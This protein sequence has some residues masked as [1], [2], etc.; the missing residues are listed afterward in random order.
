MN[1]K[2]YMPKIIFQKKN[3][4]YEILNH[5]YFGRKFVFLRASLGRF[6]SV[7]FYFMSLT[8]LATDI[9]TQS[10]A[11]LPHHK[12][13]SYDPGKRANIEFENDLQNYRK[14]EYVKT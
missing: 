13:A 11:P 5:L 12:K 4:K 1:T 2:I 7:F 3:S 14:F 6:S 10:L 9:F 8:N